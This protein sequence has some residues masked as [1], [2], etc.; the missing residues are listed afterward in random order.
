VP[1][2]SGMLPDSLYREALRTSQAL[3]A[4]ARA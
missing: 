2:V 3:A 1:A 4:N